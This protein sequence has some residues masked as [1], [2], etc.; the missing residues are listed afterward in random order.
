MSGSTIVVISTTYPI[1]GTF[2]VGGGCYTVTPPGTTTNMSTGA[3]DARMFARGAM[4]PIKIPVGHN[5]D[6][7]EFAI[8]DIQAVLPTTSLP[9]G[10]TLWHG[11]T[12][13]PQVV[14]Y[15]V[16]N[17]QTG[18]TFQVYVGDTITV[19]YADGWTEKFKFLGPE[20]G[21]LQCHNAPIA[22]HSSWPEWRDYHR[23]DPRRRKRIK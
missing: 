23:T 12:N 15:T 4:P 2:T 11:L 6:A 22:E 9:P 21:Q 19:Q 5:P 17:A 13:F 14:Y 3:F 20:A 18:Q 1:S 7:I 8:E 10:Y 16:V